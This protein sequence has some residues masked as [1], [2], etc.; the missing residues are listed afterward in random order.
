[1][2]DLPGGVVTFLF[3]DVESSTVLWEQAPDTMM[4]AL[5]RHDA[6]ID[7]ATSEHRGI[8]VKP[9]GE[10]DSRFVVFPSAVDAVAAA[11][12]IQRALVGV[13]WPTPRAIRIR[14][15]LHT[16]TADLQLGDYY[17]S[18]VN[19]AARLRAI[20]HGGQT[21]MSGSTWEL[22]QD[23]LPAGISVQDMGE[24]RLKDL[25]RPERVY[26]ITPDGLD[27]EFPPLASLND[28]RTNLPVQLTDFIGR[29]TELDDVK[30]FAG[31]SRLVTILAPGGAGKTRLAIQAAAD[32]SA[33]YRDGVFFV[34]LAPVTTLRDVPQ[35]VAGAIGVTLAGEEDLKTQLLT[36]L[37]NDRL[38]L[39]FDNLEHVIDAADI[40][41][42]ILRAAPGVGIIATSRTKLNVTGETVFTLPGL[43][44]SW[45]TPEEAFQASGVDLFID[46]AKRAD[47]SFSLSLDDLQPLSRILGLVGGMPLG[48]LLAA[49][50]VDALG[51]EEIAA[52]IDRSMDFLESEARDVPERHRSMRAVF[53]YS[54]AMLSEP[55][56]AMFAALS[57]FRGGFTRKA[58]EEVAG[59][60]VR[61]L[62]NLVG[63]SLLVSD[64]ESGRYS[65]H[66]LLR[67][68]AEEE[69]RANP[70]S[71]EQALAAHAGFYAGLA[72]DASEDLLAPRDQRAALETMEADLDNIKAVLRRALAAGDAVQTR[73]F[74][75]GL[76]F[77][78]EIRG[79]IK[80]GLDLFTE[81]AEAF[82]AAS[83][84]EAGEVLHALALAYQ[85]KLLTNL[86]HPDAAGPLAAQASEKLEG[87]SDRVAYVVA[88]E[89]LCEI[90]FYRGEVDQVR[91]LSD[92]AIR[93]SKEVGNEVYA[94]AMLN[95][96]AFLVIQQGD[97]ET[98]SRI[99]EEGDA[100]LANA[101]EKLM[102]AWTFEARA[103]IAMMQGRLPEAVD[104][105]N[106]QVELAED[107]GY[108]RLIA[109]SLQ[110]L[111]V[112]H[113]A[114]GGFDDANNALLDSL[115]R[116]ERMGLIIDMASVMVYLAR[117][118]EER[119]DAE[120]AVEIL[121]S[122]LADPVSGQQ[123]VA[124][125]AE[126]GQVAA[127]ALAGLENMLDP[128][129]FAAARTAGTARS[130]DVEVKELLANA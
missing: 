88:L 29:R 123:L 48:I 5:R 102:R 22:V 47:A 124:E 108:V 59:A 56:R 73:R 130:I 106:Q 58:A 122:V 112:A 3:T 67:Q 21:I 55:D 129:V 36:H 52:E 26:Q 63:K 107:I 79:W 43:E 121:A 74:V 116:F 49:S 80:A 27:G 68:Y 76:S 9:R 18:A 114:A 105:R 104:L 10:G 70:A 60:S 6:V 103:T 15:S 35:T 13:E 65:I 17:G 42:D 91:A 61:G 38:L 37:A 95:Y 94:A 126:I 33:A 82:E 77:L 64:R 46:A 28:V 90:M 54:W 51:V 97:L 96:Q 7:G 87:Q 110:G 125:Q 20:A 89:A 117:V 78:Y 24:H 31:E 109:L 8:P 93:V 66:E 85:A 98:A 120:R 14:I 39:V 40:V 62:A 84:D 92:E 72:G 57:V 12:D 16:G 115:A 71:W 25:T 119:G 118:H 86:G 44:T 19:R 2:A 23:D 83:G 75:I 50:W 69:L 128:E 32:L 1:M 81:V 34:D 113:A 30:R 100:V 99:L 45:D 127:E 11:A 4:E 101:D 41:S 111:G 53:D